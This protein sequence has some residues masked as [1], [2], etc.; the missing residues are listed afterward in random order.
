VTRALLLISVLA[1][2]ATVGAAAAEDKPEPAAPALADDSTPTPAVRAVLQTLN[3]DLCSASS[4]VVPG[5]F[6]IGELARRAL[7]RY[8]RDRTPAE[9]AEFTELFALHFQQWYAGVLGK[10]R[11]KPRLGAETIDGD[12]AVLSATI[13]RA[14]QDRLSGQD[15]H[16]V[17]RLHRVKGD[18]WLVYDVEINGRGHLRVFY[19]EFDRIIITDGYRA[20]VDRL[21]TDVRE[22]AARPCSASPTGADVRP[23]TAPDRTGAGRR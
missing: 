3:V 16:M 8:H 21:R 22:V 12:W 7:G 19:D 1:L 5:L 18:R 17:Y 23:A 6:D 14:G 4:G 9:L 10:R 15:R 2:V 20:L 13:S 11:D